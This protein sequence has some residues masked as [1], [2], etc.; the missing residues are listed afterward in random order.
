MAKLNVPKLY[1][2]Y[3]GRARYGTEHGV[4]LARTMCPHRARKIKQT[5]FYGFDCLWFEYDIIVPYQL[6]NEKK[7]LDL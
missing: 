7:R 5:E 3:D 1:V 4:I 6:I 2:L